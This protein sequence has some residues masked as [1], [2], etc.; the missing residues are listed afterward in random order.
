MNPDPREIKIED[1]NYDLP[2]ERIARYPL[3]DRDSSK[4]LVYSSGKI[5]QD[6]FRN[7]SE[8]LSPDHILVFNHTRVIRAR[9]IF[10]KQSGAAIEIFCL[11]PV[12]P[13]SYEK[14]LS[15]RSGADWLCLTGN[16][17]KWKGEKLSMSLGQGN[18]QVKLSATEIERHSR[19][20][21]IRFSW[22]NKSMTFSDILNMAGHVPLP[23]Y[24]NR[25]DEEIDKTRYQTVYSREDGSVAA[26]TAGL[27]FTPEVLEE[28]D[29]KGI[30]REAVSLH[31]GAGT[32]VPVKSDTIGGHSM[33]TEHFKVERKM[34]SGIIGR[35]VIA[36]GTT[37][38]RTLESLYWIGHKISRGEIRE[39]GNIFIEQWYPYENPARASYR[40]YLEIILEF[41]D[42]NKLEY[43]LARTA[44][45]I[46]PG[47]KIRIAEGLIT[48]YH[49]PRS[50]L[51]LLVAAF[52][53]KHW[54]DIY[55][56]SLENDFR[57]L[58]YGDSSLLLP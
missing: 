13:P 10:H 48:N 14:N 45:I 57:F 51:L 32:F 40:E 53:G 28:L 31:V 30:G 23:P 35:R 19:N 16:R 25:P 50:T 22:D 17:K 44:I 4:L 12:D 41:M 7:I 26:P 9:M 20:S 47:Y 34:I 38:L 55:N 52:T 36:V 5:K 56:Y 15:S 24:L 39:P 8:Y 2:E 37:S 3:S 54:R 49:M 46:V 29:R 33:H 27:H 42:R 21:I 58:S 11:E 43:L 6:I 18:N 1:Y